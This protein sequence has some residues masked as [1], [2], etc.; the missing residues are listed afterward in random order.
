MQWKMKYGLK[1]EWGD[2][3]GNH[4]DSCIFVYLRRRRFAKELCTCCDFSF[5]INFNLSF[6]TSCKTP[7]S[8]FDEASHETRLQNDGFLKKDR[9]SKTIIV[10]LSSFLFKHS[11]R[12][13]DKGGLERLREECSVY[14][15]ASLVSLKRSWETNVF[16][17]CAQICRQRKLNLNQIIFPLLLS[18]LLNEFCQENESMAFNGSCVCCRSADCE[19]FATAELSRNWIRDA[20]CHSHH[21]RLQPDSEVFTQSPCCVEQSDF[22]IRIS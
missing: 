16:P 8:M 19:L 6:T 17:F 21:F 22:D 12:Q 3:K 18:F 2:K 5:T 4:E 9:N 20:T 7:S 1:Q 14:S 10:I 11:K 15:I 13:R